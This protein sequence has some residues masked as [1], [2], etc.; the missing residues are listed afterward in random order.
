MFGYGG[1]WFGGRCKGRNQLDPEA[2]PSGDHSTQIVSYSAVTG[3]NL[4]ALA[5]ECRFERVE[6]GETTAESVGFVRELTYGKTRVI[7]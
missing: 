7:L 3:E 6:F 4:I 1:G 5:P 2:L